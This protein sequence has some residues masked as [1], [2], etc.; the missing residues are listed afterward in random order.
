MLMEQRIINHHLYNRATNQWG[1]F[2]YYSEEDEFSTGGR[3]KGF[4]TRF[5]RNEEGDVYGIRLRENFQE[6]V[7]VNYAWKQDSLIWRAEDLLKQGDYERARSAYEAA[8]EAHPEHYYLQEAIQHLEYIQSITTEELEAQLQQFAG[9]YGQNKI[10]AEDGLLYVKWPGQARWAYRPISNSTFITLN[11]YNR[12]ITFFEYDQ[13]ILA[14]RG[15]LYHVK[16]GKWEP[17]G[18]LIY[19]WKQ[20]AQ[21]LEAVERFKE[22]R[23]VRARATC[24]AAL[25]R[26]P[27]H[28]FLEQIQDHLDYVLSLSK[29]ELDERIQRVTGNYEN[30]LRVWLEGEKLYIQQQGRRRLEIR[31]VSRRRFIAVESAFINYEF[32]E[33]GG[34]IVGLRSLRYN[35]EEEYWRRRSGYATRV[36]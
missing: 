28:F 18:S 3:E 24:E 15:H 21:I 6:R 27:R 19:G 2:H 17:S 20:D 4:H 5:L 25:E 14:L 31:P 35:V 29:E 33:E 7:Y 13:H 32:V 22:G 8:W 11:S 10:W 36:E 34:E 12:K 16:E 23:N 26:H 30:N 9:Q 1:F